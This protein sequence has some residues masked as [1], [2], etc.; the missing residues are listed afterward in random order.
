[1]SIFRVV[2]A[3]L[4]RPLPYSK[5]DELVMLWEQN[6]HRGWLENIIS[7][8]NFLDWQKQHRVFIGIAAFESSSFNVTTGHQPEEIAGERVSA[9][10][11]SV[12]AFS[13]FAA[14]FFFP[15]RIHGTMPPPS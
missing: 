13:H 1:M 11:F 5:A 7:G 14:V 15:T 8:E 12:L 2:N 6:A 4:F 3:V 10:L 9:N